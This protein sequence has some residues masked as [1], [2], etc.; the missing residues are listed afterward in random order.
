MAST[1]LL[2]LSKEESIEEEVAFHLVE[3][4]VLGN[5]QLRTSSMMF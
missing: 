1:K 3:H 5:G 4:L 2:F